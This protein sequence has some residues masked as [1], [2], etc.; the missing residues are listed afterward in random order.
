MNCRDC[1]RY[2]AEARMCLDG[3][4]NPPTWERTF[5]AAGVYGLRAMCVLSDHRERLLR[6][7]APAH[8]VRR[9]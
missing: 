3:K 9:R 1:P 5:E 2:N 6:A 7:Y 4:I 8:P